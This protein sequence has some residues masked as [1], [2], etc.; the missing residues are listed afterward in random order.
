MKRVNAVMAKLFGFPMRVVQQV[1]GRRSRWGRSA[2]TSLELLR[3]YRLPKL[4]DVDLQVQEG[5]P[6]RIPR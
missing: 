6:C 1:P 3:R 4:R 5:P 2:A